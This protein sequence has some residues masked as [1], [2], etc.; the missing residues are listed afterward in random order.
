MYRKIA[1]GIK[2]FNLIN[3]I[4]VNIMPNLKLNISML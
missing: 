4:I 3:Y 1:V 2:L